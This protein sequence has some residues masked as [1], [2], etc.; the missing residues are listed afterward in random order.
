MKRTPEK[1]LLD[2]YHGKRIKTSESDY[3]C[4][5]ETGT[6]DKIMNNDFAKSF[7]VGLNGV[8]T[9]LPFNKRVNMLLEHCEKMGKMSSKIQKEN[10]CIIKENHFLKN[11]IVDCSRVIEHQKMII[12]ELKKE[13]EDSKL[14]QED[15]LIEKLMILERKLLESET[16]LRH[17]NAEYANASHIIMESRNNEKKR[18]EELAF[19]RTRVEVLERENKIAHEKFEEEVRSHQGRGKFNV[20][21]LTDKQF[22]HFLFMKKEEFYRELKFFAPFI[23]TTKI[24]SY[25]LAANERREQVNEFNNSGNIASSIKAS[26]IPIPLSKFRVSGYGVKKGLSTE[27][28]FALYLMRLRRGFLL[29]TIGYLFGISVPSASR[30]CNFISYVVSTVLRTT[31]SPGT[32]FSSL[33]SFHCEDFE[34]IPSKDIKRPYFGL[35]T[36]FELELNTPEKVISWR[37]RWLDE[38]SPW[39]SSVKGMYSQF[40]VQL[41]D[42]EFDLECHSYDCSYIYI[43][44]S[45]DWD[46]QQRMYC[47]TKK[48]CCLKLAS[49]NCCNG[50]FEDFT[51]GPGSFSDT[52]HFLESGWEESF[53][54]IIRE[55]GFKRPVAIVMDKGM[56]SLSFKNPLLQMLAPKKQKKGVQV[57]RDETG[58]FFEISSSRISIEQSYSRLKSMRLL[59]KTLA[60]HDLIYITDYI[61]GAMYFCNECRKPFQ[62]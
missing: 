60:L 45:Y 27:N 32:G 37:K 58:K 11:Q 50:V 24:D 44:R 36:G 34:N 42:E 57:T 6:Y 56:T 19:L 61:A 49:I 26:R 62:H 38:F 52:R 39:L 28:L 5:I 7:G 15:V 30:Y 41:S 59:S 17:R 18:V 10:I 9:S 35:K 40:G 12:D 14:L 51:V 16:A 23:E 4:R 13:L 2:D 20:R 21:G 29:E 46:F 43:N 48:R 31:E 55:N 33:N 25:K 8:S 54:K 53:D 1:G 47:N 22:I 3:R